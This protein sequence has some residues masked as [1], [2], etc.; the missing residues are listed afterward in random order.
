MLKYTVRHTKFTVSLFTILTQLAPGTYNNSRTGVSYMPASKSEITS[1]EFVSFNHSIRLSE[2]YAV[3]SEVAREIGLLYGS[4]QNMSIQQL[5]NAYYTMEKEISY[6]SEIVRMQ[7]QSYDNEILKAE[8]ILTDVDCGLLCGIIIGG[9]CGTVCAVACGCPINP[10]CCVFC[11]VA[12]AI[13]QS[14]LCGYICGD[15]PT[16]CAVGCAA[17]CGAATALCG[18][19][20]WLCEPVCSIGCLSLIGSLCPTPPPPPSPGGGGGGCPFVYVWNGTRYILDNNLLR[21]SEV[22]K[23]HTRLLSP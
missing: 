7:L 8:A 20:A 11:G 10:A 17:V 4:S 1:A 13:V 3:L 5:A 18:A 2:H 12:C 22:R 23:R 21:Y 14:V 9:A 16:L 15:I 19:L 6:L